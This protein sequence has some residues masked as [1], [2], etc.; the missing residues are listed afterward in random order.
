MI[1]WFVFLKRFLWYYDDLPLNECIEWLEDK[2]K[3]S[4]ASSPIPFDQFC[5]EKINEFLQTAKAQMS[6]S[7]VVKSKLKKLISLIIALHT[8]NSRGR[9]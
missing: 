6:S 2:L 1:V 3:V 4:M 5:Q 8:S 7:S 9:T